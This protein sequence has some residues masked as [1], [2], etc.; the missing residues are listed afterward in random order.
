[1]SNLSENT[2]LY[3]E[4]NLQIARNILLLDKK[5]YVSN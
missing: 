3:I 2:E 1:M 4:A 5:C